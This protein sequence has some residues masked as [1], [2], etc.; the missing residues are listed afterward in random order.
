M[1]SLRL[2]LDVARLYW[3]VWAALAL[4]LSLM[5]WW[6]QV[7]YFFMR[8]GV[9]LPWVGMIARESRKPH[10]KGR[11]SGDVVWYKS[12]EALCSR[13]YAHYSRMA[14]DA[15]FFDKC[16]DYLNKTDERGRRPKS[17]AMWVGTIVLVLLE[18]YIFSL[19]LVPFMDS[20]VS[21]NQA[22]FA[23]WGLATMIAVILVTVTHMMGWELHRN[24]L[25]KKARAWYENA[26]RDHTARPL[27]PS[28]RID[29]DRS[30]DDND[31]P[32]YIQIVNRVPHAASVRGGWVFSVVA[33]SMILVFAVGAYWIR[34]L[35]IME[36]ETG[37]VNGAH[38]M[39]AKPGSMSLF[40]LPADARA[41]GKAAD[42]RATGE[43]QADHIAAYRTTFVI[44]SVIFVGI[45]I[46]GIMVGFFRSFAGKQSREA[47]VFIG[48]FN[49]ASEF[50][51]F[52]EQKGELISGDAQ[53][54]LDALHQR[55]Q[56][57]HELAGSDGSGGLRGAFDLYARERRLSR[58][59]GRLDDAATRRE[60]EQDHI[61]RAKTQR[62]AAGDDA[63]PAAPQASRMEPIQA[64]AT[65]GPVSALEEMLANLG[66]L[67]GYS[68]AELEEIAASLGIEGTL[69]QRRRT[70]QLAVA[71]ARAPASSATAGMPG[72]A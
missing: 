57:R 17:L 48:N 59:R 18:A 22:V 39:A 44:L 5:R 12:E 62:A 32:Q 61:Q 60:L 19:V 72:A 41:D 43:M 23:A 35:T 27:K 45:Q 24:A 66:D 64:E 52:Y 51:A 2:A 53:A 13:F 6:D 37:Q 9:W 40:D 3:Y 15:A 38:A 70:V 67:T 68:S 47:A 36:L 56:M 34:S 50:A 49:S 7:R 46:V 71:R 26:R 65:K 58:L 63:L 30:F 20:R 1:D 8:L 4:V 11:Q 28:G 16:A 29:L 14:R 42:D 31:E 10:V 55:I 54:A 33:V 25:L 21:A 69:L